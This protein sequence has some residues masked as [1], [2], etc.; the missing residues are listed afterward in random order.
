MAVSTKVYLWQPAKG[1]VIKTVISN[2]NGDIDLVHSLQ[3]MAST[4]SSKCVSIVQEER[5]NYC[6]A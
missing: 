2:R 6:M 5:M 4:S 1:H 3:Y